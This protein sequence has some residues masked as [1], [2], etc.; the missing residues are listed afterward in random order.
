MARP[1]VFIE[2][3]QK[4]EGQPSDLCADLTSHPLPEEQ[5]GGGDIC[6]VEEEPSTEDDKPL[7]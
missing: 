2:N 1:P 6:S 3:G 5:L 4:S 7:D